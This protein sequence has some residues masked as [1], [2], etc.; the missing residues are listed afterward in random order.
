MDVCLANCLACEQAC[1]ATVQH[2]LDLG[3]EHVASA[4]LKTL[5]DCADVCRASAALMTSGSPLSHKLC[6]VCAELCEL[7]TDA[8]KGAPQDAQMLACIEACKRCAETCRTM[9][10]R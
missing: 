6:A 5:L 7:C 8:C 2:C 3:G 10:T 1:R 9:S 4:H